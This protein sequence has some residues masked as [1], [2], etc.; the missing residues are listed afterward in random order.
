MIKLSVAYASYQAYQ[1][2]AAGVE[3]GVK[4]HLLVCSRLLLF[5]LGA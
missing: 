3:P 5:V 2:H 4:E 1:R